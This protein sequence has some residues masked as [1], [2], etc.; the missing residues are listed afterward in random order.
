MYQFYQNTLT[1]PARALYEDLGVISKPNYDK[2]CRT[3]KINR[4]RTARGLD[5]TALVDFESIPERFRVDI[6]RKIGYPPK[7]NTQNLILNHY[8]DDFQAIDFFAS[9]QLDDYRTLSPE[10][11]DEY[12]KNAQ[13]LDAL[14]AYIKEIITFRRSRGGKSAL[15]QIWKDAAQSVADV[16]DQIGHTLPK[17]VRRLKEKL[18]DYKR[19]GYAV[20]IS[21]NFGNQKAAKVKDTQQEAVLRELLR[22]HQAF[23]N[24]QIADQYNMFAT[25]MQWKS[26]SA[27][28]VGNYR[29]KWKLTTYSFQNGSKAFDN[30]LKMQVKRKAPEFANAMWVLDG[31]KVELL[32]QKF[33]DG[34]TTYH[35]RLTMV[36]V[37]D[38]STKYPV[39]YAI[40][41]QENTGLIKAAIR[42]A[43]NH[44][45]ELFGYKHKVYQIQADN[46]GTKIMTP[47]YKGVAKHYIPTKVGNAK[48]K[49]IE[50]WFRQFNK[51]Y[52]QFE[53]N[54]SGQGVKSK[55]QPNPDFLQANRK[56]FPTEEQ[57]F[58]QIE[59]LI[60]KARQEKQEEYLAA[61]EKAPLDLKEEL[62]SIAYLKHLGVHKPDTTKY[63]GTGIEFRVNKI[64]YSYDSFNPD[65]RQYTHL[66][67]DIFFDPQ[68][69]SR[70]LAFNVKEN[71][72][73]ELDEKYV[74]PMDL[75]TQERE[76]RAELGR[77]RKFNNYLEM[78]ILSEFAED[79]EVLDEMVFDN[80]KVIDETLEK[81]VITDS[82][83]QHKDQR[84]GVR[85]EKARK[86]VEKLNAKIERQTE[87][88]RQQQEDEYL[89]NKRDYS[90][91]LND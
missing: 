73:F 6:V 31:W 11:Q 84:N 70:V 33:S 60:N 12:V 53:P 42:N 22:K 76:D 9:Y 43:V 15:T 23:D 57:C 1:V 88:D 64:M 40:G 46:Y 8:H 67:W 66:D 32:Y 74:Q 38:P 59:R 34:K 5:N 85:A 20:L 14:D 63:R 75:Y 10:H 80:K 62:D 17:S 16:Q 51:N 41:E 52:C 81:L 35:N 47:I 58:E 65:F 18:E 89:R 37:L 90:K 3:G 82:V 30:K 25:A 27:N 45:E 77:I 21:E 71:I 91:Y 78:K 56:N 48:A 79:V 28:T 2:L 24:E 69:M 39:G 7:K 55:Q 72:Q 13:M 49:V 68:D 26:I 61:Y 19:D 36:V 54:W 29:K 83:G 50:P 86:K 44:T 4:V 87:R